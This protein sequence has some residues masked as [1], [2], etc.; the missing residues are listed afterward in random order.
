MVEKPAAIP[1]SLPLVRALLVLT[2]V[3]GLVDAVSFISLGHVFT[4]NMTGNVVFLAFAVAGVP[5]LSMPRSSVA[6]AAFLTG[7]T[8]GGRMSR[9]GN[10]PSQ[11]RQAYWTAAAFGC[12]AVLL[13]GSAVAILSSGAASA[14]VVIVMT[15]FAMGLRNATVRRLAVPDLTTTV[16]TL[17]L[18]GLAAESPLAGSHGTNAGRRIAAIVTMFTG[19]ALGAWLLRFSPAAPLALGAVLSASAATLLL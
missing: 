11:G 2:F 5:G 13:L 17:T 18:T 4:A 16:L 12:E 8:A 7:A 3:A 6:L 15:G 14:Y 10:A 9:A 19:A 1:A